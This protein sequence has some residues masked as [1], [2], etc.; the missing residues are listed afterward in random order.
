MFQGR[1]S[2]IEKVVGT[3]SLE[4]ENEPPA[5]P[6]VEKAIGEK[7]STEEFFRRRVLA[8][9][10]LGCFLG[11]VNLFFPEM[12]SWLSGENAFYTTTVS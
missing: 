7:G 5:P 9:D 6:A 4:G 8:W 10:V 1:N 12:G 2:F 3:S 11:G